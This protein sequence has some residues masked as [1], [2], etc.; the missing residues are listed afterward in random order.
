MSKYYKK[1]LRI[2]RRKEKPEDVL[3]FIKNW[4][5]SLEREMRRSGKDS[6]FISDLLEAAYVYY[7]ETFT[8]E[9]KSDA[10]IYLLGLLHRNVK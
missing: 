9:E 2:W 8:E 1:A 3:P 4:V 6:E 10:F 7:G 5:D